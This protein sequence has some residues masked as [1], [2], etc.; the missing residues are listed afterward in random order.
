MRDPFGPRLNR[1][2]INFKYIASR[3]NFFGH[4]KNWKLIYNKF[5]LILNNKYITNVT[6]YMPDLSK[7]ISDFDRF[8]NTQSF[9]NKQQKLKVYWIFTISRPVTGPQPH[10]QA[11]YLCLRSFTQEYVHFINFSSN[12]NL[13]KSKRRSRDS[14]HM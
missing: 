13:S 7:P 2:L 4:N 9:P 3:N 10:I 5:T 14:H 1:Q 8:S 12:F 6:S 11:Y